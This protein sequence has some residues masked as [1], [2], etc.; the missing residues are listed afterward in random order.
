M[1]MFEE[2]SRLKLR[3]PSPKG[4]L[5]VEDL[6]DLPLTST[7]AASL[8]L[9]AKTVNRSLKELDEES[10]VTPG[11]KAN[12]EETLK[13]DIL[14]HVIAVRLE[15][16]KQHRLALENKKK[17]ERIMEIINTKEDEALGAKSLDELRDM[18][19]AL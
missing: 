2:A 11:S 14:K 13:L 6:W 3:F 10:F 16:N 9:V 1:N 7:R 18:L 5:T 4:A 15:E 19:N 8:D 17:K 12:T